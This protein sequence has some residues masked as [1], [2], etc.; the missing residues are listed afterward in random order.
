[1]ITQAV[2]RIFKFGIFGILVGLRK[3]LPKDGPSKTHEYNKINTGIALQTAVEKGWSYNKELFAWYAETVQLKSGD[4]GPV[5]FQPGPSVMTVNRAGK[6][7]YN[8][9]RCYNERGRVTLDEKEL[10]LITDKNNIQKNTPGVPAKNNAYLPKIDAG[11]YLEA[12][13]LQT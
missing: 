11:E 6:R 3:G 12:K 9:K 8:E 7:V 13:T 10:L 5:L 1:M 2:R 4:V